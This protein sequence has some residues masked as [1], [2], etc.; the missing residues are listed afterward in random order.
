VDTI[1]VAKSEGTAL[2]NKL[3][4]E[5]QR[6]P[7]AR[8]M[9]SQR[10]DRALAR[11]SDSKPDSC[12]DSAPCLA[13]VGRDL[14]ADLVLS[15]TLAG[16]GEMRLVRTRLVRSK[17]GLM[18]HDFQ[19]TVQRGPRS[20]NRYAAE[21]TRRL[22]PDRPRQRWYRKWWIWTAVAAAVG[23]SVGVTWWAATR[24]GQEPDPNVV[25]LGDL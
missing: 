5:V 2:R 7:E 10:V 6:R 16:L 3:R 4:R 12:G 20:L 17:D 11:R 25:R 18:L 8:P 1:G 9:P 13:R 14:P 21:L 24:N 15:S 23:A 22:F 19:E